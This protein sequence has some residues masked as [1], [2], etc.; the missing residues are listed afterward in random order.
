M[1]NAFFNDTL[2]PFDG[3]DIGWG[4]DPNFPIGEYEVVVDSAAGITYQFALSQTEDGDIALSEGVLMITS[5]ATAGDT[6]LSEVAEGMGSWFHTGYNFG[7]P[8]AVGVPTIAT[9]FTGENLTISNGED[10]GF[11]LHLRS[12]ALG[13]GIDSANAGAGQ[14]IIEGISDVVYFMGSSEYKTVA[15][16]PD[17]VKKLGLQGSVTL[18][19]IYLGLAEIDSEGVATFTQN[20]FGPIA[21]PA[22][23]YL[24]GLISK[25]A[26]S[27]IDVSLE[28]G[29]IITKSIV[30]EGANDLYEGTDGRIKLRIQGG[31]DITIEREED[32]DG[33][34]DEKGNPTIHVNAEI[35][36]HTHPG[37]P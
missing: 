22:I 11:W 4:Q 16:A 23:S 34:P 19:V 27:L 18:P 25:E 10:Y 7:G 37:P 8:D 12:D 32:A 15:D 13:S 28:D 17:L 26:K 31:S 5:P 14:L 30:S 29:G 33:E 2:A 9:T 1:A 36:G 21:V 24:D 35:A 20:T 3:I 6:G